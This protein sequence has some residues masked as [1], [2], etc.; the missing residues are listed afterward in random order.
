MYAKSALHRLTVDM[1]VA[2]RYKYGHGVKM[3]RGAYM[4]ME[5]KV[6]GTD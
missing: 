6:S 1:E 3:V 2:E 4:V 5:R